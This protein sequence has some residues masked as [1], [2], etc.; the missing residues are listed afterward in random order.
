MNEEQAKNLSRF[1][2]MI[3][4]EGFHEGMGALMLLGE[5]QNALDGARLNVFDRDLIRFRYDFDGKGAR[6]LEEVG[7]F[8]RCTRERVR[9]MEARA[10]KIIREP[11]GS[12]PEAAIS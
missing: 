2:S 4:R 10:I 5:A 11:L 3:G 8:F 7:T 1:L 9:Q 6:T 12:I